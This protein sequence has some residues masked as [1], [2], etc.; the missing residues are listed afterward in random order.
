[1][2]ASFAV[3]LSEGNTGSYLMSERRKLPQSLAATVFKAALAY[4]HIVKLTGIHTLRM[5]DL[6][7]I[8]WQKTIHFVVFFPC[9][10]FNF[11]L[12]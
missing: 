12:S 6:T 1:M 4:F 2:T 5:G 11:L 9:F 10:V 8:N 3:S 7:T